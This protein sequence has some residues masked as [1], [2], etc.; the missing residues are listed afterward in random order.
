MSSS[1]VQSSSSAGLKG[2]EVPVR[3]WVKGDSVELEAIFV[4]IENDTVYLKKPTDEEQLRIEHLADKQAIALQES[5]GQNV[6]NVEEDEEADIP[7]K[8][9]EIIMTDAVKDSMAANA[10]DAAPAAEV[11]DDGADD[12]LETALQK[13]EKRMKME[14][15]AKVEEEIR[16]QEIADS[17]AAAEKNPYIKYFRFELKRLYNMEDA[18]MIPLSLSNYVVPEIKVVMDNII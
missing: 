10:E 14:E 3:Y 1:S 18:A 5:N 4:K 2:R 8:P 11:V 16:N 7:Q 6:E 15:I 17:I 12:D 13:E 9:A